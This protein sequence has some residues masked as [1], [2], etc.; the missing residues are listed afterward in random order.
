MP[1]GRGW[2]RHFQNSSIYWT[3]EHGAHEVRGDIRVKWAQV[4][5]HAGR[6]LPGQACEHV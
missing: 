1:D 3:P 4:G 2:V 6:G 5:G